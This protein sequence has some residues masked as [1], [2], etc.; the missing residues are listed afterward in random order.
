MLYSLHEA[1]YHSAT[2]IRMAADAARRF[3]GSPLN[4]AAG[5][6]WG[7]TIFA[8]AEMLSGLTRRYGR[9]G[10]GIE[11][12]LVNQRPVGVREEVVW[13]TP[14]VKLRR[15]SREPIDLRRARA[16]LAAPPLLIVAPL[17]GHYATLLRGTVQTFLQDFDV[18]VTDWSNARDVPIL[19][20]RFDFND[21]IDQVTQILR[22]IGE[23]AHVV[24][25]CQP[26]PPVLAA[27]A[28][29]AEEGDPHRPASVS[30]LGSPIDARLA[31]TQTNRLAEDKPFSWFQQ[32]MIYTVPAPYPG[33]LRRVY[34]G[35][36]QLYSFISMNADKHQ[37]AHRRYFDHLVVG[38]GDS[39]D[40]HREFY[41]EYLS[42]L[43]LTEEFYL[44]TID[45]V[46]QRYLLPKGELTHRGRPVDLN[47]IC[48]VAVMSVEGE[49]DDISGVGQTQ[50][51]HGLLPNLP[52]A[53]HELYVQPKVGHYGVFNGRR[54]NDE[55]YPRIRAFIENAE[56]AVAG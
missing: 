42:V 1:A 40:K 37:A 50:A 48:D 23:R 29:L 26:G 18:Y 21:Y 19:E 39:A 3:W 45:V 47:A 11:S 17:S 16:P 2:P 20:G 13:A 22:H 32:A 52:D 41:D 55:I 30:L 33:M 53:L 25:V 43:D 9:P 6:K 10:W 46:F 54:F 56:T 4:P 8:S 27:A 51:V 49:N 31:P 44:Q 12:V 36:V 34:P 5:S 15:F 14:W 7:R 28:L 35:F 38:D 24:A